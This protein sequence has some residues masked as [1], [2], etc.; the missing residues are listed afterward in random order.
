MKVFTYYDIYLAPVRNSFTVI[1]LFSVDVSMDLLGL[2]PLYMSNLRMSSVMYNDVISI[3]GLIKTT[4][5]SH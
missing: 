2:C 4:G 3:L 5:G 1:Q